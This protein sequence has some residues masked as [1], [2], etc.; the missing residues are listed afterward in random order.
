MKLSAGLLV[1]KN[2]NGNLKVL[3][4]HMG[5]PW[6]AKKDKGAWSIP[7]GEYEEGQDPLENAKRE[8]REELG[9][10]VPKGNFIEL[11]TIQQKNNKQVTAWAVETE[12]D[13]SSIKSNTFTIEWP[14]RSGKSAEFPEVDRAAYFD[15]STASQKI[16]PEQA[17]FLERLSK[18][19]GLE[20]KNPKMP[21]QSSLF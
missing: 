3:V 8:F 10:E 11:G 19:L 2:E 15:I 6:W 16:I 7:K 14:P 20:S 1:Y 17:E 5:S 18:H 12:L 9:L 4:A 13:V 21:E